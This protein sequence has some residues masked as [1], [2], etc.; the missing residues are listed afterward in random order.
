MR[1][2]APL[3]KKQEAIMVVMIMTVE[4]TKTLVSNGMSRAKPSA[5]ISHRR[6]QSLAAL[7]DGEKWG[8]MGGG[9]GG[10]GDCLHCLMRLMPSTHSQRTGGDGSL[11]GRPP[12][13]RPRRNGDPRLAS[14]ESSGKSLLTHLHTRRETE[15]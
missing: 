9:G 7:R 5:D 12:A 10:G 4:G 1:T 15:S 6:Q 3:Q 11:R 13:P 2:E 8:G 14:S